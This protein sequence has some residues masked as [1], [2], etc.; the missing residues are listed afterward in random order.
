[1]KTLKFKS[2]YILSNGSIEFFHT[3]KPKHFKFLRKD[4][5]NF[6]FYQK[7]VISK[8][9]SNSFFSYKNIYL[10]NKITL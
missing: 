10:K 1:M 8:I 5:I 7:I 4:Q 2:A 3:F 6:F 9:K